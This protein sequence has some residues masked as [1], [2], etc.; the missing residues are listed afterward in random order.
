MRSLLLSL[1]ACL[2]LAAPSSG[3]VSSPALFSSPTLSSSTASSSSSS[4]SS[5]LFSE[6]GA[7]RLPSP[8]E[9][10]EALRAYMVKS[11]ANN[12][13]KDDEIRRL[14]SQISGG[15]VSSLP[16]APVSSDDLQTLKSRVAAYQT[17][18]ERYVVD[19][20]ADKLRAVDAAVAAC[21]RDWQARLG[22][23]SVLGP[24]VSGLTVPEMLL[25]P[26]PLDDSL[27]A[28]RGREV[29]SGAQ[30]GDA[31]SPRWGEEEVKKIRAEIGAG[32][33]GGKR[34]SAPKAAAKAA[35]FGA[36]LLAK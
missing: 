23:V 30:S 11:L 25:P 5:R 12:V 26:P 6:T 3:F 13:A 10:A 33:G 16:A 1:F 28:M 22:G 19:T 14:K 17:F 27:F 24:A 8:S 31:S 29:L 34:P 36:K 18:I 9:S 4:S 20:Q 7:D 32:G 35:N 2:L 21:N 15:L